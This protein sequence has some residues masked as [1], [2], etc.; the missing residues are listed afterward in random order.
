[1]ST[2]ALWPTLKVTDIPGIAVCVVKVDVTS[3]ELLRRYT[4]VGAAALKLEMEP[5]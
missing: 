2:R 5:G 1:M 3:A 4:A